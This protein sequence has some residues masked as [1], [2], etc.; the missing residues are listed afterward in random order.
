M[1][2]NICNAYDNAYKLINADGII[3]CGKA[4]YKGVE[5]G[6]KVHRDTFHASL[7][8]G[9]YILALTW[10]KT[11]TGKDITKNNFSALDKPVTRKERKLAIKAVNSI[12]EAKN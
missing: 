3:P 2:E 8:L 7:G 5:L 12:F 9:R 4:M 11:L 6:L 1:F 10:Y